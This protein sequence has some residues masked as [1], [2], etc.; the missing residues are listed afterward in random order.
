LCTVWVWIGD[1]VERV[2]VE[3]LDVGSRISEWIWKESQAA[4]NQQ[5]TALGISAWEQQE[6]HPR[7][8]L[9]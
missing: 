4:A 2:T 7:W 8:I 9:Y 3:R 5:T 6:E 1:V